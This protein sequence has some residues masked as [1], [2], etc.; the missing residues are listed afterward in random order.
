[1]ANGKTRRNQSGAPV[2]LAQR[3]IERERRQRHHQD[4]R[5]H[6][7]PERPVDQ[8]HER[9]VVAGAVLLLILR[10][11]LVDALDRAVRA[12]AGEDAQHGGQ[13]DGEHIAAV[14]HVADGEQ[15]HGRRAFAVPQ[16]L[17]RGHLH[18]LRL[19]HVLRLAVADQPHH[20]RADDRG[21]RGQLERTAEEY[22]IGLRVADI[23][24][25]TASR[26]GAIPLACAAAGLDAPAAGGRR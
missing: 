24:L 11:E 7:R 14:R 19:D 20:H 10:L 21:H 26:V 22:E 12:V 1:M 15:R 8:H 16:R 3:P 23:G 4:A 5:A 18:R 17:G 25:R 13:T 2:R 6:H 9:H